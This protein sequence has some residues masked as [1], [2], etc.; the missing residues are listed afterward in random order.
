MAKRKRT[1]SSLEDNVTVALLESLGFKRVRSYWEGAL[2]FPCFCEKVDVRVEHAKGRVEDNQLK[3]LDSLLR[4]KAKLRR[5]VHQEIKRYVGCTLD[6]EQRAVV[7]LPGPE[8]LILGEVGIYLPQKRGPNPI[9]FTIWINVP[10]DKERAFFLFFEQR[11][12][13]WKVTEVEMA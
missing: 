3:A 12:N 2:K 8:D 4:S 13:R 10:W 6:G 9:C 1:A 7:R 5:A 11:G